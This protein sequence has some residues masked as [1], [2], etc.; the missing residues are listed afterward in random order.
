VRFQAGNTIAVNAAL[1][2]S[3]GITLNAASITST[4]AGT[5]SA[6]GAAN[7]NAG[8][9]T[10][11]ASGNVSLAGAVSASGGTAS[12]TNPGRNGGTISITGAGIALG[13]A[14]LTASG[15]NA[16]GTTSNTG[17]AGGTINLTSTNGITG[18]GAI[19]ASG[20]NGITGPAT[21]GAAGTI[22]IANSGAGNLSVGALSARSGNG[23]TTGAGG[24][25]GAISVTNTATG[26]TLAAGAINTSGGNN[27][28]S[29]NVSL[30]SA[31]GLSA[32]TITTT[33]GTANT[34]GNAG[35]NAGNVTINAGGAITALGAITASG[36]AATTA[37]AGGH[38]GAVSVTAVGGIAGAAITASG[39]AGAGTNANGGNAGTI[40]VS[41]SGSGNIVT[42]ALAASTGNAAG[43]GT[44]GTAGSITASNTAATGNLTTGTVTTTGGTKGHGGNVSL[45]ALG[46]LSTGAAGN[47]ATSGGASVTGN[48]GRSAGS[49]TLSGGSVSTGTG[50]ITANGS[51]G[52]GSGQAGGNGAAVQITATGAITTGAISTVGGAAASA[53]APAAP[54]AGGNAGNITATN[55]SATTGAIALGT[56]T[57]TAGAAF[58]TGAGGTTGTIQVTNNAANANLGTGAITV[59]GATNAAGG[60]VTLSSQGGVTVSGLINTTGGARGT[61][62]VGAGMAAGNITITGTNN[63]VTGAITASGGTALGAAQAG[64][65]AGTVSITG[66]GTLNTVGITASGGVATTTG[67]GGAAGSITLSG[68]NAVVGAL[69]TAGPNTSNADGG[70]ISITTTGTLSAGTV[71]AGGGTTIANNAGRNAGNVT[72]NAGGAITALGAITASG[73]AATTAGAGGHGGAVSVTA[74]GGIA[75]AAITASGA[76][77]AGTNANGGNAGTITVSNS[78][79]GNIVTGALAASTG[80]AAGT[81]TAGTAG[82]ITASNTA[83]TGNLTTG[84]VTTTGGTKGHGGN[85]SL[86]ALGALSTGAAGNIATSGGASV[87]GNAGRSAGSVTLS[88][89]SVS[90][91]TGTITA[92]GSA[93]VGTNQAGGGAGAVSITATGAVTAGAITSS[94]GNATG[95]GAG[96][97]A[98]AITLSGGDLSVGNLVTTGGTRGNGGHVSVTV[99]GNLTLPAVT[100]SAGA[101]GSSAGDVTLNSTSAVTQSGAIVAAGLALKGTGGSYVL[102]HAGNAVTT[103]AA[104][105]ASIDYAQSGALTVGTVG[106]AGVSV[107]GTASIETTG[108]ASNLTLSGAVAAAGTGNALILKAGSSNAAGVATGGQII[109]SVGAGGISTPN[110]RYLAYSGDPSPTTEGVAGYSKRYNTDSAYVPSGTASHFLYRVAPTLTVVANNKSRVYGDTN[111]VLDGS[112]SGWIDDDTAASVG[113]SFATTAVA[114]TA[115][116]AGPVAITPTVTNTQNYTLALTNGALTITARPLTV[117]ATGQN[118][119]YDGTTNAT[120]TLGDNRV[121]GDNLSLAGT[122]SFLNKNVGTAKTVNVTGINVTGTAAGNYTFNTTATTA[123]DITPRA[124]TVGGIGISRVYDGTTNASVTPTD[125]RVAGDVLTLT[126]T[127]AFADKHVGTAKTINITGITV[128]GTD[129]GNYTFNTSATT[130]ADITARALTVSATGQNKVYDGTTNATVTLGD[131]R[132]AGDNLSLAGT[133]SFVNKNVGT[134]K[135]IN[136]TGINVTGTDAGNYSFNTT[137]TTAAD[138]TARALTVSATGQNKVYDGTTNATVTLGDNRVA[139]DNLSL[140]GTASFL[141]K[142]VGTAKT[143]NVTGINVTGTAAGN[144]TFNTTAT[145]AADIT[146]RA[147]T[148]GGIGISRVYDGTTNA[149]VTPTDNRVAGDVLT[150]TGTPAFA[151]KHVGTAKTI[152]IT[153]ITVTGTDAGNYTFNTSATTTADI[154]AR[155]LTVSATGQNKVYDGTTVATVTLSDN[156]VAGDTLTL[157][158]TGAFAS[159]DVGTA[160]PVNVTGINITGADAGNYTFNTTATTAADITARTL[161][162]SATGQNKVY[163]GGTGATVSFGDNRVS[164]DA[165]ILAGTA[166]F[167][168]KNVGA[169]K[170]VNV[171]GI[172]VTGGDSGNYTLGNTTATTTADIT[173]RALTVSATGQNKVYDGG[174]SA[175]VT[176][177]DNRVLGD[178]LSLSHGAASFTDKHAGTGKTVNVTG[179]NVTGTDASN[180]TFNTTATTTADIT[181]RALTVSATG[182]NK[183]YDG[184]TNATVTLGDNRVAGDVLS[185]AGTGA[186]VNKNVGTAKT[187]NVTGINVTGTDA[188]N[189]T[190][191]TTATT[192]ADITARALTV[193]AT[194]QNKVYDGTTNATV[195]LG[196]NRVA[197]D[198]LIL[199]G[200]GAFASKDVG[201]AKAV[202]VTGINVTG[203]DAGNYT[204][205]TTATT[206]A[207]ITARALTV[208]ATGQNRVY[209]GTTNATVTLGDNRVAGDALALSHATA[210]FPDKNVGTGKTVNV[211]GINVTGTDAGNYTFNTTATTAADIT[212]RALTVSATGQNKVYDGTT[213]ATVTLGDN[214]VAG[215]NLSLAGTAS[216]L[217]KNVGTAKTVNVTGINV[218]GTD[219]GNYTFNTTAT[220]AADITA[221]ALTVSATGQNKVYDGTTVAPVTLSDNRVAGDALIL[222]GTGAFASKDVGTAKAVNVTG[223]NVTG[224]D[225]GNYTFNTTATTAADITARALTVSATGQNR[226]YDGTTNATVTLGD[227]RVAGDALALSHA[228]ASFPDKNVGTGKTV[229]VTGINVTGTDAGNY[230]FNTTATTAADITARA[231]TVSA[232]GQNKV[233]DGT[234]NA[235]VTLGDNRVAGDVL[236]LAGTGAFVN[237]NVGTAKTVNVTGINVTGTDAGNYSFNTTA[238][239][240]ADITARA[241]TI[242][243]TGQN[244]VYD[245][246]ANATV[247]PSDDRVAGDALTF[248][249]TA[250]F[251][252]KN[253]GTGKTIN[254]TGINL[255]GTDA[256]NYTYNTTATTAA[257][258]TRASITAVTG[259]TAL[260]KTEDGTALATLVLGGASFTGRVPGDSLGVTAATGAFSS[261]LP[262]TAIPVNITGITLGGADA[263]N[264]LLTNTTASASANIYP[265]PA[266]APPAPPPAPAPAPTP[267]PPPAPVP[268]PSPVPAPTPPGPIGGGGQIPVLPDTGSGN[269]G[270]DGGST[271]GPGAA[272]GTA[273]GGGGNNS[274]TSN[275]PTVVLR[276]LGPGG[277]FADNWHRSGPP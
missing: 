247:T 147:L 194:G 140:A 67:A 233:Y 264:Y 143:V 100:T 69:S 16:I 103:L 170:A 12:G 93:G 215:D 182:Q 230:T 51:A 223:I 41:N 27:G 224:T 68:S 21:G 64:G 211:T 236:S 78:G 4:A 156:R 244:K 172:N 32:G 97:T 270:T 163:D 17:G 227:N 58:G 188:G 31:G 60:N 24:A 235:T 198:A 268:A 86:S 87:T 65:S 33:G 119:V 10:L 216:F 232:T 205:N 72:I 11:T 193:S 157:A 138:I 144:Y 165:L 44:A 99:T 59:N 209:D 201:T 135:T 40:T 118:K 98:G 95:T 146:P 52:V 113:V 108:A 154:T 36:S 262:G 7:A 91:G 219:A 200:T 187:V 13:S 114:N 178:A 173:A 263:G 151:D 121:A 134:A 82:S 179:I 190:F 19:T 206:A 266:P 37:G 176:L 254:V 79:S 46:A 166:S 81:G 276:H 275:P 48:A 56:L 112:T 50:T 191:N 208:S 8:N 20:G 142:N 161:T 109:N 222:A 202:N 139:G 181:A 124:L 71:A 225:A 128:T 197:G 228:T 55:N 104:D 107:T 248:T 130:T 49:V 221:R 269:A 167:A 257:D 2:A 34:G 141:N 106:I 38:G 152:N 3:G 212:A 77:G 15:S 168:D 258:I 203:T 162:V 123:A 102:R 94:S 45:S 245:G 252:N 90:T 22:T 218:T 18:T 199:A 84:T 76:A 117:T 273:N 164:G 126:G 115:V 125:N 237:K 73:S 159:K 192:A 246:T 80:N 54:A 261:T 195:T 214:R 111:P 127:P 25:A 240:A 171:T 239:T 220:T 89:G 105:T 75:G 249:A 242:T 53:P 189:Y 85:V 186:F 133:A 116:A 74:V 184:T 14:T 57:A 153:G 196:D 253:V 155:A 243:A 129:A 1:S 241:L 88:G 101:G 110:G 267:V 213:N 29:G 274:N 250:T 207:D 70:N 277:S 238:T 120:V 5:I 210:S 30:S 47:I 177:G 217:N 145:T 137:A 226:V 180:Y 96:G 204:F 35:R 63:S 255:G 132:V 26:A 9:V 160:K 251:A 183:V 131:N 43:T 231:L 39:A 122:A 271:S 6:T 148:V 150:L 265:V 92:N 136:V 272:G 259:I 169:A 66:A 61:G 185:L 23:V 158:G 256:G 42:G 174:S 149:S 234:T 62:V 260:D 83:A 229:N 28:E 175:T